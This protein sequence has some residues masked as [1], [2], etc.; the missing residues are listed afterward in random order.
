MSKI[1]IIEDEEKIRED[2]KL[3]LEGSGYQCV[4][5]D[6]FS[7]A[8]IISK[9]EV[10]APDLILLDINLAD[11]SGFSICREIRRRYDTPII[12]LTARNS[13]ADELEALTLGG[14]DFIKKPYHPALLLTRIANILKKNPKAAGSEEVIEYKGLL[15]KP[16]AYTISHDGKEVELSKT[17]CRLL[18]FLLQHRGGVTDRMDI[19]NYLWDNDV[20]IDDNALSVNITRLR[21]RLAEVKLGDLIKTKRGAGYQI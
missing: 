14:G 19:I 20:F 21:G 7:D 1:L 13:V 9:L 18:H 3:L 12:F 10:S 2:L 11:S 16:D 6:Q 15:F 4:I 17:E 5:A 8:F